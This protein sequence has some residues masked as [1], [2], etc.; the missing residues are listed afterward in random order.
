LSTVK[1]AVITYRLLWS[2]IVTVLI[3]ASTGRALPVVVSVTA[4]ANR[5]S[6][7]CRQSRLLADDHVPAR[8]ERQPGR[9]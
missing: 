7:R 2:L 6:G 4:S 3:G 9:G 8:V 1:W 5:A